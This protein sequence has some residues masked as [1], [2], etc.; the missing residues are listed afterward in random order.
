VRIALED[1]RPIIPAM[2]WMSPIWNAEAPVN[3]AARWTCGASGFAF[4]SSF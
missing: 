4:L 2:M 3:I 1:A